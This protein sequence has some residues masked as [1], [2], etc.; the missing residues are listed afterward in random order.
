MHWAAV[1][2]RYL[3]VLGAILKLTNFSLNFKTHEWIF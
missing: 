2:K 3:T 1:E